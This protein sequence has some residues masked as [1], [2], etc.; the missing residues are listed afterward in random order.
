MPN[1]KFSKH[2]QVAFLYNHYL[3]EAK[4]KKIFLVNKNY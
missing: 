2:S 1:K 3:S 4:Q